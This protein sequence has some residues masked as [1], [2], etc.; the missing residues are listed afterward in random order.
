MRISFVKNF[1]EWFKIKPQLDA[2]SIYPKFEE[3]QIWWCYLG[4]NIGHEEN[5]KGD[6]FLRPVVILKK[7]NHRIF[8]AIPT[9]TQ[10]KNNKYYFQINIKGR[11]VSALLSQMRLLDAKRLSYRQGKLSDPELYLLKKT[12]TK[13]ILK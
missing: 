13:L 9:S 8:Y 1:L 5:G 7:F 10:N 4:E 3:G 12:F 2:A 11:P 6:K